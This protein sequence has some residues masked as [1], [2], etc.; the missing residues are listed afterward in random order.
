MSASGKGSPALSATRPANAPTMKSTPC[1]RL[2]TPRTP[3]TSVSPS[4]TSPYVLPRMR[5]FAICRT[6]NSRSTLLRFPLAPV[7]VDDHRRFHRDAFRV[8]ADRPDQSGEVAQRGE[9]A[10]HRSA[11]LRDACRIPRG[12]RLAQRLRKHRDAFVRARLPRIGGRPSAGLRVSA[13]E[14][15]VLRRLGAEEIR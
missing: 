7:H 11:L 1:A 4:A 15:F 12:L 14:A 10:L 13:D 8:E 3:K 2:I 9:L 5:P 6:R